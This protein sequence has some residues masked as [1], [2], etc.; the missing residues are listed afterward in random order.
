MQTLLLEDFSE[1]GGIQPLQRHRAPRALKLAERE[2]ISRY[3]VS[4]LSIRSI[5]AGLGRALHYK[6]RVA[7]QEAAKAIEQAF[8]CLLDCMKLDLS[9]AA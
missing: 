9:G 4:G 2:E 7:A 3:P 6:S 5:A 1:T 8:P